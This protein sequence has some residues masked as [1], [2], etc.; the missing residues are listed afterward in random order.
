MISLQPWVI[1][2]LVFLS[3]AAFA[4]ETSPEREA[5]IKNFAETMGTA[6]ILENA[7]EQVKK[8]VKGQ[9]DSMIANMRKSGLSESA[10]AEIH[11]AFDDV[12]H[13]VL[14]SWDSTEAY[15][16]YAKAIAEEMSDDDLQKTIVFYKSDEGKRSS[17]AIGQ[18][19]TKMQA[20][21]QGSIEQ[22]MDP[23][24]KIFMDKIKT[25]VA[26]DRAAQSQAK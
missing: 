19:A 18:A 12:M 14:S 23:A 5:L 20:Y 16:I 22:A 9:G 6:Q 26:R 25:I 17:A 10:L 7:Q 11:D 8:M 15:N 1:G 21:V 13:Q 24:M 2:I 4:V 3:Q